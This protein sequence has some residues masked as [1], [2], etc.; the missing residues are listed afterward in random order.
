[1]KWLQD[2]PLGM[3]LA[4]V[5]GV[6][7]LLALG[8]AIVWNLPVSV[9]V[10][11]GGPDTAPASQAS[12]DTREIGDLSD[13]EV[14]KEKPVFNESRR[15]VLDELD[16]ELAI[17]DDTIEVKDAPDVRLTGVVISPGLRIASLT[18]ADGN[19]ET[20]MA[21]EGDSLTGEFVGWQ[22]TVVNPRT[23]T[24]E[25]R[26]GQSLELDLQ[27]HDVKIQEPPKPAPAA[28]VTATASADAAGEQSDDDGEEPLSRAEQ[29]R[30][31]IAERREELRLEQEAQQSPNSQQPRNR[32]QVAAPGQA[33]TPSDYQSAIRAMMK[34]KSKD[35]GSNDKNDG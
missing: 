22:V 20:V 15:P 35:Q 8:M 32:T 12:L 9:D 1:M 18:P 11:E 4:G 16:D 31:R 7:A 24:L 21:H 10:E 28:P 26:D 29:I 2:N 33:T 34:N 27:V 3:I 6:F 14:V 25:S 30:Q 23:V 17:D 5:S 13:Y 19:L